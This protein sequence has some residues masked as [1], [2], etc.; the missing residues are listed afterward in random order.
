VWQAI[1]EDI[2]H[3]VN[4]FVQRNPGI[5]VLLLFGTQDL[6]MVFIQSFRRETRSNDWQRSEKDVLGGVFSG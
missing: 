4:G 1:C 2:K 6:P 3:H 5:T